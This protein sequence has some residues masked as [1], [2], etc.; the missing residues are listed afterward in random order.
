M[1]LQE[2]VQECEKE[3]INQIPLKVV[4]IIK[5]S[6]Y[7]VKMFIMLTERTYYC[8]NSFGTNLRFERNVIFFRNF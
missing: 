5:V 4:A 6:I 7:H 2:S 3:K 1:L 8:K